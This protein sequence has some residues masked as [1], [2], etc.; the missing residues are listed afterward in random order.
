[1]I[2][3]TEDFDKSSS[4][5]SYIDNLVAKSMKKR[6]SLEQLLES[7]LQARVDEIIAENN[8]D[9][10]VETAILNGEDWVV[11]SVD[12]FYGHSDD[13][14]LEVWN[15]EKTS[16]FTKTNF[17]VW[18]EFCK[19]FHSENVE[20]FAYNSGEYRPETLIY[21]DDFYLKLR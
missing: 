9:Q 16:V 21:H 4:E 1:M 2:S 6:N 11:F 15:E 3:V 19:R 10:V 14:A 17:D 7:K 13:T 18:R 20:L 8:I 12:Q 5:P